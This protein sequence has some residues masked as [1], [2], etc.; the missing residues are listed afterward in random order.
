MMDYPYRNAS[1]S[2][3]E[4]A[5]D[6]LSRMNLEEKIAQLGAVWSYELLEED[7]TFSEDKAKELLKNGIGQV[8]RPGGATN[9]EPKDVA[10]FVNKIQ[11]FLMEET[12]LGIPAMMH[13][14]S[15]A[16]Y[17]GLAATNFPQPIAM[18][19]TWDPELIGK[20]TAAIRED[21]RSIGITHCLA[22][23]LDVARDPR[24]GRTEETFG[25]APYLIASMGV[26]YVKNLQGDDPETG[27]VATAKHF[28][29]YS[30][31]EG[32]KNWAP[33]NIPERELREVFLYPF[34]AAVK[35]AG[36]LSVMNSYSEIDGIPC[37]S[38]KRLLTDI[39][40][41]EWG[42]DGIVVSDYFAV[43]MLMEYHRM[44]KDKAEA[45][46]YALEA[47]IDIELPKTD[48]YSSLKE[49]VEK[50]DIPIEI[51]NEA[52]YRVLKIKFLLGLFDEPYV[53]EERVP[54][55]KHVGLAEE[56]ARKSVI[57]L[58]NDRLLPLSRN[59][60]VAVIG[61]H[62]NDVRNLLGDYSYL[63][64]ITT[65]L[66][67]MN[68]DAFNAPKFNLRHVED[69]VDA[70]LKS[71][72]TIVD[73]LKGT[74]AEVN[75][76]KGCDVTGNSKEGFEEAVKVAKKSDV[77]ILTVGDKSGLTV[78]CT[79][80]ESRDSATL[81]LPGVQEELILEIQKLNKPIVLVLITGRPYSLKNVID[82]VNAI[83]Q[84]WLPGEGG[85]KAL[86]E[87]LVGE[88]NPGGK[89]PISYPRSV[90]QIPLF[91][92]VKPSG[93]RSHW[94]GSYADEESKPLFS[95]GYGLSYTQ[96]N[97]SG[98]SISQHDEDGTIDVS[99][100]VENV[101]KMTGDEVVQLYVG[102][103]NGTVT[104]PL[105]ELRGFKR[106]T[107]KPGEKRKISFE[108]EP[109]VL[110]YYDRN[111]ELVV[112]PGIYKFMI[113]SSCDDIKFTGEIELKGKRVI[114]DRKTFFTKVRDE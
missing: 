53:P 64:H 98:F 22:P 81:K 48:C 86:A 114:K 41:N 105:K 28:V 17:M 100:I 21:V 54:D 90:G 93:G 39:L 47:G 55:F 109:E 7:G 68:E 38:S 102:R 1:L 62:A 60:K 52:V 36:L 51:L 27:V 94:H 65:L 84:L 3:D 37:A 76:A 83:V 30:A 35:R 80:G 26:E 106:V 63:T 23:V 79:T 67:N 92:Y 15:L 101:G 31:S 74:F 107:L 103:E 44:A 4:R 75:Y 32:G 58:K 45:A 89:L 20:M 99:V 96:F 19:S 56:I 59:T 97:Y 112:E 108:I 66:Q 42:F 11:R 77:I 87:V 6:L 95:F 88:T 57:L 111:M 8:T 91:H 110:S 12:R 50:G 2:A 33:T 14:E 18:A 82:K 25:E 85:P 5:R 46:K 70:H 78:D 104:R 113:G 29:G 40:R 24:W 10:K 71:I 9:F 16:G 49:L 13:E 43:N 61:P 73:Q 72:P 34:E 69:V